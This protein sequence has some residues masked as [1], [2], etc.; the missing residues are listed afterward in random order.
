MRELRLAALWDAPGAF[1]SSYE[2]EQSHPPARWRDRIAACAWFAAEASGEPVGLADG[3][4]SC[5]GVAGRR[6][7]ISMWVHPAHRRSGGA[8]RLVRVVVAWAGADGAREV[9]LWAAD[10]N[11]AAAALYRRAGFAPTGRRQ[12]LPSDPGVGE[13]E[14]LLALPR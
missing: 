7:L 3:V 10:G 8:T 2:R 5:D 1:A 13:E 9:A 12:P 6:D 11:E 4:P 14:W